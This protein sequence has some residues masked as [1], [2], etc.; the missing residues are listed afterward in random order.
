MIDAELAEVNRK[1]FEFRWCKF[2]KT[3]VWMP[4]LALE[5]ETADPA[6]GCVL[7]MSDNQ[8]EMAPTCSSQPEQHTPA[9]PGDGRYLEDQLGR[10]GGD[11]NFFTFTRLLNAKGATEQDW[12]SKPLFPALRSLHV[13]R[14]STRLD[15]TALAFQS[16]RFRFIAWYP[17]PRVEATA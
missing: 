5:T 15:W 1:P 12:H 6:E 7:L 10:P 13:Y 17:L 14:C 8:K 3:A 2:K 9:D 11:V 16:P 4:P